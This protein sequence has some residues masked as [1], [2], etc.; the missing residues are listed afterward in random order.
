MTNTTI[1]PD[2]YERQVLA[3]NGT[4]PGPPITADWGDELVIHVTN[5]LENNGT[6]SEGSETCDLQINNTS[7]F[8]GMV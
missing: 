6:V 1:A 5:S 4:V 8:I 7:P 3:F 2:G